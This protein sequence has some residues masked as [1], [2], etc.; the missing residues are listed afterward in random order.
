MYFFFL[1]KNIKH[2]IRVKKCG[3]FAFYINVMLT[4]FYKCINECRCP[5]VSTI[6]TSYI[7]VA[8]KKKNQQSRKAT[9]ENKAILLSMH[10][11]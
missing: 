7:S 3:L 2:T 4:L 11:T 1:H 10:S 8:V 6:K 9:V 5:M